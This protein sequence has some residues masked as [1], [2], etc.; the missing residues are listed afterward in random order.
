[1]PFT[2]TSAFTLPF[3]I[4]RPSGMSSIVPEAENFPSLFEWRIFPLTWKGK[5][6]SKEIFER[7]SSRDRISVRRGA[8]SKDSSEKEISPDR[9]NREPPKRVERVSIIF[10][11][12][13][14]NSSPV[15]GGSKKLNLPFLSR[16]RRPKGFSRVIRLHFTSLLSKGRVFA[17]KLNLLERRI[18]KDW[19]RSLIRKSSKAIPIPPQK[20]I[21]AFPKATSLPS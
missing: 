21:F 6:L 7:R 10:C 8:P 16:E 2:S 11:W 17:V 18:S 3:E 4:T 15:K 9:I 5:G 13:D 14:F 20:P 19:E 1:M 12:E